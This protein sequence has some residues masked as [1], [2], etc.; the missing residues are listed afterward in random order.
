MHS[1]RPPFPSPSPH[2]IPP[3]NPS[4]FLPLPPLLPQ[5]FS[6]PGVNNSALSTN[7]AGTTASASIVLLLPLRPFCSKS[8]AAATSRLLRIEGLTSRSGVV[9]AVVDVEEERERKGERE[10]AD[11]L[12]ERLR[13]CEGGGERDELGGDS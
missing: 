11:K 8:I 7:T 9:V 6:P 12:R 2:L 13:L 4:P 3:T 1:P 5:L 10:K